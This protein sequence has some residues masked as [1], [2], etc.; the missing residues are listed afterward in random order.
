MCSDMTGWKNQAVALHTQILNSAAT[1]ENIDSCSRV[2]DHLIIKQPLDPARANSSPIPDLVFYDVL[3]E[4]LKPTYLAYS[5]LKNVIVFRMKPEHIDCLK[6]DSQVQVVFRF[7]FFDKEQLPVY[8]IL[9]INDRVIVPKNEGYKILPIKSPLDISK[10]IIWDSKYP[11]FISISGP[12][13]DNITFYVDVLLARKQSP[14]VLIEDLNSRA[15]T[16]PDDTHAMIENSFFS[17]SSLEISCPKFPLIC[18]LTRTK[19]SIPCRSTTCK[20]FQCFDGAAYL[21]M[22]ENLLKWLCPIC[23]QRAEFKNLVVDGLFLEILRRVPADCTEVYFP[24]KRKWMPVGTGEER[25]FV[26]LSASDS[27]DE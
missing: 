3:S 15:A 24:E 14:L 21:K 17:D 5:K 25:K 12:C 16:N 19:I 2:E 23:N 4:L 1:P 26:S 22:N 7:S 10:F 11:Q 6:N 8:M 13:N 27:D 18:P 9:T 20:H